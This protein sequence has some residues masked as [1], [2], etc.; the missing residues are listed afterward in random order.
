MV[1]AYLLKCKL[2]IDVSLLNDEWLQCSVQYE[3]HGAI[4]LISN[5]HSFSYNVLIFKGAFCYI[6][7]Q[8]MS[9]LLI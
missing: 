2:F 9:W 1:G 5:T 7:F 6:L 8:V 3:K 4:F